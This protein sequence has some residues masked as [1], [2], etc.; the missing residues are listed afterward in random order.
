MIVSFHMV[1]TL[2]RA[3]DGHTQVEGSNPSVASEVV[4]Q[5]LFRT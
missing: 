2:G 4:E 1:A 3:W 5:M